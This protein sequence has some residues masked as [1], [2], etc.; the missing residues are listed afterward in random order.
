MVWHRSRPDR[1]Y[2]G[3]EVDFD[4]E[5]PL[6]AGEVAKLRGRVD[7]VERDKDGNVVVVD[8]KTT[9]NPPTD[10][11]VPFDPQLGLYQLAVDHGGLAELTGDA[12]SGGAEL[13]QLRVD[14]VAGGPK[15]QAQP[16]QPAQDDGRKLVEVQLISAAEA[17]RSERF[18][19]TSNTYCNFCE[20][21]SMCPSRQRSG[22]IL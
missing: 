4:V 14:G 7:R 1:T 8:F 11:S 18:D 21:Q 17:I 3:S 6:E 16:P 15:V 2:L 12:V 5:V 19:A 13:V 10:K 22:T 20:F 9:K